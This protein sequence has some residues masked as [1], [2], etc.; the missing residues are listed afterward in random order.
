[1]LPP[2]FPSEA[3]RCPASPLAQNVSYSC[4]PFLSLNPTHNAHGVSDSLMYAGFPHTYM[5]WIWLFSLINLS[6]VYL[7]TRPTLRV[8]K[9]FFLPNK[10]KIKL[11]R[12]QLENV[13]GYIGFQNSGAMWANMFVDHWCRP[14]PAKVQCF[15]QASQI[16][17]QKKSKT[18]IR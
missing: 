9:S 12:Y 6:H 8:E 3:P 2:Q 5:Y 17:T 7:I 11:L 13:W 14:L 1:M 15:N 4:F 10:M 18:Q 16:T